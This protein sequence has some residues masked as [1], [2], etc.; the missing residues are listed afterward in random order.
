MNNSILVDTN[1]LIYAIDADS[2]FHHQARRLI[3]NQT[4]K[5]YTTSKNISEFLVVLTRNDELN[6]TTAQCLDV[7]EELLVDV[8][9]LYPNIMTFKVFQELIKK[10]NPRGLW[11]HDVEIASIGIAYGISAIAT[12]NVSDFKRINEIEV[13]QL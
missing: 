7:L 2:R 6:V 11:I 5:L 8:N 1:I 13:V 9:I 10:Y 12:K 3:L 4:Y